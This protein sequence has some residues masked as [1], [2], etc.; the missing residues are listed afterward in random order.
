MSIP[1]SPP[2]LIGAL[3]RV[4][5]FAIHRQII[6][7]LNAAGFTDLRV[8]HIAI[9]NYPGADGYRPS[10]LAE[11]SGMSKQAMNQLLQSLERLGYI[12]R[13]DGENDGRARVVRFT[14]RGHA[15]WDKILEILADIES[16][17]RGTLGDQ[18]FNQLKDLLQE[19]CVSDLVT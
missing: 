17:W 14:E 2:P 3:L 15:A 6:T 13:D 16:D 7:R 11:R 5:A 9:F 18:R 4:P 8:P 19:V 12:R 1:T 10:E